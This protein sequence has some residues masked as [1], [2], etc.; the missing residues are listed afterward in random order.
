MSDAEEGRAD[1]MNLFFSCLRVL[2]GKKACMREKSVP[3]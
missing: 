1:R 2:L 3:H